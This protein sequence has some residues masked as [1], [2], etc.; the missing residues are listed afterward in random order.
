[1]KDKESFFKRVFKNKWT[2]IILVVVLAIGSY[3][4]LKPSSSAKNT[5]TEK[6]SLVDLKQTVLS[7]GQVVSNT[8][9][10]LS[11]NTAGVVKTIKVKVGD[12]VKKGAMLASLDSGLERASLTTARGSLAA[13]KAQLSKI[14]AGASNEEISLSEI[15]LANAERDYE[16]IK[17]QQE[18]LVKNAYYN[19]LNSSPEAVPLGGTSDYTAPTISGNYN[20]GLEG[21]ININTYYT[22][23]GTS[24]SLS[25]ITSGSGIITTTTS[26]PIGDSGL[27]ITFPS[28]TNLNS[29]TWIITIPNIKAANYLTNHNLYQAALKT[30]NSAISSAQSSVDQRKA[31]LAIR[32]SVARSSDIEL[33]NANILSAEGQVEQA[34][35]RYQNTLI[36]A[37]VK[38]T[39]T[40]I[41]I[42][43]GEITQVQKSAITLQDISNIYLETNINEANISSLQV[44]MPIE[45]TYDSFGSDRIF[46]GMITKI[47]PSSTLVSGVVN[48][49]ITASIDQ[50]QELR[51]GMTANMTIKVYEKNN[52]IA[53][54]SRAILKDKDGNQSI[55]V[56][57][58]TK[59]K[60]W[61]EVPVTTGLEGDGGIVEV[62]N[63]LS[64]DD[65]Y[66]VL[67][68]N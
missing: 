67:I 52:I 19:L 22:G 48:Y 15:A 53:V 66:V 20:L 10:S 46:N 2:W 63:G 18:T 11:F 33:A 32:K 56:I 45:I 5:I 12:I 40:S 8:D 24:F 39:V 50:N 28:T 60:K 30:K 55:R 38:G 16:N 51:P 27:Y 14:V 34:Y 31:E 13:A 36:K 29:N 65:E 61:K 6:A 35:A 41:D 44:G 26:Q 3:I 54:P 49:K 17:I 4:F 58:N 68:K 57:T 37:P 25:G 59:N 9:L 43:I 1:M 23:S 21:S 47:D 62:L 64:V 7:T 42:K